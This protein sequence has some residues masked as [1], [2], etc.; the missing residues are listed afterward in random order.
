MGKNSKRINFLFPTAKTFRRDQSSRTAFLERKP[1]HLLVFAWQ[2]SKPTLHPWLC[3]R[4]GRIVHQVKEGWIFRFTS[5]PP[6]PFRA[7]TLTKAGI[8]NPT[9]Q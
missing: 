2:T 4:R 3:R 9:I 8:Q 5:S 1:F 6:T 7:K